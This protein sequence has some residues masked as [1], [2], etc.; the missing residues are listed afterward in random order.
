MINISIKKS[1]L[2]LKSILLF[3]VSKEIKQIKSSDKIII[4]GAGT[5]TNDLITSKKY[6]VHS[7]YDKYTNL[8]KIK[9]VPVLRLS[10]LNKNLIKF[11]YILITPKYREFSIFQ[12]LHKEYNIPYNKFIFIDKTEITEFFYIYYLMITPF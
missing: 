4:Y 1:F 11:D 2:I 8:N 7:I 10:T 12:E 5:I 3:L 6:T 9:D